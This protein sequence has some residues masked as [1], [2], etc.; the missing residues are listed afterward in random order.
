MKRFLFTT[1]LVVIGA[2]WIAAQAPSTVTYKDHDAVAAAIANGGQLASG[3]DF[4]IS[5]ARRT[6]PSSIA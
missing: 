3:P 5:M 1:A 2:A 4:T 6:G